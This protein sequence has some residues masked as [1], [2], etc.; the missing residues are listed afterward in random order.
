MRQRP[1][2]VIR[3]AITIH[4]GITAPIHHQCPFLIDEKMALIEMLMVG[5]MIT[6]YKGNQSAVF[7]PVTSEHNMF[8]GV[9]SHSH[10]GR[11]GLVRRLG[12]DFSIV[13]DQHHPMVYFMDQILTI[14]GRQLVRK[15]MDLSL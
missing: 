10:G 7:T 14:M 4:I 15:R 11:Q 12:W 8:I 1:D 6:T 2:R 5:V 3:P 9:F 13:I